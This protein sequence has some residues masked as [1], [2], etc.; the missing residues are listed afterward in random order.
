[1]KMYT[2]KP[3]DVF[4]QWWETG[5]DL[6]VIV[7]WLNDPVREMPWHAHIEDD[8]V[9]STVLDDTDDEWLNLRDK[10]TNICYDWVDEEI[11]RGKWFVARAI[12]VAADG[13]MEYDFDQQDDE[14]FRQAFDEKVET[15]VRPRQEQPC[16]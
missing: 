14:V 11:T 15:E 7:D 6:Q 2:V 3:F 13:Q 9:G 16:G 12:G 8:E 1:M 4:A 10:V 5:E